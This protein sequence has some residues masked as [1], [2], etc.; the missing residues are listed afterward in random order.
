MKDVCLC[1]KPQLASQRECGG[2]QLDFQVW[3]IAH[4]FRLWF[5]KIYRPTSL[6]KSAV[7]LKW[8]YLHLVFD[9]GF[10]DGRLNSGSLFLCSGSVIGFAES[11]SLS[12]TTLLFFTKYFN[13]P[14]TVSQTVT[15]MICLVS[16][17]KRSSLSSR[18]GLFISPTT[19]C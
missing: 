9:L 14:H 13:I 17:T 18:N 8:C 2:G 10:R 11:T 1:T 19:A 3:K 6:K 7:I 5:G 16:R 15:F 12:S 4:D